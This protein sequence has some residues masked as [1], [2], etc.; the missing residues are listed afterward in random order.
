MLLMV[1]IQCTI[2][3]DISAE[4]V[5]IQPFR[6]HFLCKY[7]TPFVPSKLDCV[8][9]V[10]NLSRYYFLISFLPSSISAVSPVQFS[11]I[12]LI[13]E[14]NLMIQVINVDYTSGRTD[15]YRTPVSI[16]LHENKPSQNLHV[17]FNWF[18]IL[19][20]RN[21]SSFLPLLMLLAGGKILSE[22]LKVRMDLQNR[23]C[24]ETA[25]VLPA[26]LNYRFWD[27]FTCSATL[28][29]TELDAGTGLILQYSKSW[30]T[31]CILPRV[32]FSK[33]YK[34][35]FPLKSSISFLIRA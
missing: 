8:F 15:S 32:I 27:K 35:D 16:L 31:L 7:S 9:P 13:D 30:L 34:V 17:F 4:P 29:A 12:N 11:C 3:S 20:I 10:F 25:E 24:T 6:C 21:F 5:L 23:F 33:T 26:W 28:S 22:N 2:R 14:T 18:P 19:H 1:L